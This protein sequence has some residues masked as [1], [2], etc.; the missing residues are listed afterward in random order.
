MR[1]V[2]AGDD[3]WLVADGTF[4]L[5]VYFRLRGWEWHRGLRVMS[6]IKKER[7]SEDRK[8]EL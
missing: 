1:L 2:T 7:R 3:K 8:L 4:A 6:E 5:T